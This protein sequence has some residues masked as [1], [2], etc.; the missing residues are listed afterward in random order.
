MGQKGPCADSLDGWTTRM[1]KSW[2]D[3]LDGKIVCDEDHPETMG[4]D[5]QLIA[6]AKQMKL[7]QKSTW[8]LYRSCITPVLFQKDE[9][10]VRLTNIHKVNEDNVW[11]NALKGLI[12]INVDEKKNVGITCRRLDDN[13]SPSKMTVSIDTFKN[14]YTNESIIAHVAATLPSGRIFRLSG[15]RLDEPKE[16]KTFVFG[17]KYKNASGEGECGT[18]VDLTSIEKIQEFTKEMDSFDLG[19][20]WVGAITK[21]TTDFYSVDDV[22]SI[23]KHAKKIVL[24]N[25]IYVFFNRSHLKPPRKPL[26]LSMGMNGR[27][28]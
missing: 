21:K 26:N 12:I 24:G 17:V 28:R 15:E 25:K 19:F 4:I 7:D 1:A 5:D 22:L 8:K 11:D 6:Q 18:Y 13:N 9:E 3:I 27:F 16:D 10:K 23:L 2:Q 14:P 20:I